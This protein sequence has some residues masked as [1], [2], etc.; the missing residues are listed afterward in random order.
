MTPGH[1]Y[2]DE[3]VDN[4]HYIS[5]ITRNCVGENLKDS[6]LFVRGREKYFTK[7]QQR[8]SGM[9]DV[10]VYELSICTTLRV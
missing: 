5:M 9:Y 3:C 6:C 7:T 4:E 1:S 10:H 8:K 2:G